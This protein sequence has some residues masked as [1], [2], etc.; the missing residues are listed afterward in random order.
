MQ[1]CGLLSI[2]FRCVVLLLYDSEHHNLYNMQFQHM[3]LRLLLLLLV[4][5]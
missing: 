4:R 3:S 5:P 1:Q 2:K